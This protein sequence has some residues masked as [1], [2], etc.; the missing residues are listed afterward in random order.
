MIVHEM[1]HTN[2]WPEFPL[3][4]PTEM[5][6]FP[7]HCYRSYTHAITFAASC[8]ALGCALLYTFVN[9]L[10]AS[11]A[12]INIALYVGIYTPAKRIH[13]INTWIG[14]VIGAI[15]PLIGW[16]SAVGKRGVQALPKLVLKFCLVPKQVNFMLVRGFLPVFCM[17]GKSRTFLHYHGLCVMTMAKRATRCCR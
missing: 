8:G 14:A 7:F 5:H 16:A 15:P 17:Y 2:F 13:P 11:L 9:P 10:A 6:L 3:I 12:F 4:P 1:I